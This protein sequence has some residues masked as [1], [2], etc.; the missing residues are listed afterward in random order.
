MARTVEQKIKWTSLV[1]HH[2]IYYIDFPDLRKIIEQKNNWNEVF[3]SIFVRKD[4]FSAFWSSVEPIR[5]NVAHNRCISDADIGSLNTTFTFL[6]NTIGEARFNKLAAQA[7]TIPDIVAQITSLRLEGKQAHRLCKCFEHLKCLSSWNIISSSW[8]FDDLYIGEGLSPIRTYFETLNEYKSLP[9]IRGEGH[10]IEEWIEQRNI[11]ALFFH[12][13][14][15]LAE[16]ERE[17]F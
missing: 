15:L 5:N 9:R 16:L 4:L 8:W 1:P 3:K 17:R 14:N 2:P 10:K 6:M 12:S 11:D 7:K 13:D